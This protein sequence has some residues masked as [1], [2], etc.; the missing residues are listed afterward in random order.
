MRRISI[1]FFLSF[2]LG[3]QSLVPPTVKTQ[4]E[5]VYPPE[6]KYYVVDHV[7]AKLTMDDKGVPFAIQSDQQIPDNVVSALRKWRFE[8]ASQGHKAVGVEIS[9]DLPVRRPLS[10]AGGLGRHWQQTKEYIEGCKTARELDE[11]GAAAVDQA[12]ARNPADVQSRLVAVCYAEMHDSPENAA[13][14]LRNARWFAEINPAFEWLGGPGSTPRRELAGTED[15]E[16]LRKLWRQKL[17]A[18]PT[19]TAILDNATNFLRISDPEEA[20]GAMLKAMK[21]PDHAVDLLGDIYVLAGSGVT[22]VK[23]SGGAPE[24]RD[25]KL[26]ATPFAVL[27]R[28][29]LLKTQNM[30]LL[31][32]ALRTVSGSSDTAFCHAVLDR[33]K[34]F[35]PEAEA[36]CDGAPESQTRTVR[37]G[38]NVIAPKLIKTVRP[39][40]P[41]DAKARGIE[42]K[43]KFQAIIAQNGTIKN[44][45][46]LAGPF[47]LY[48]EARNAVLKWEYH[49]TTL[50]GKPVDVITTIDVAFGLSR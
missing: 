11:K 35:Y 39:V 20:A 4:I 42:G 44:L 1:L 28:E 33:A 36:D 6:L 30:R 38:G 16:A 43:V 41:P 13:A 2:C 23:P 3:A 29:Q 7:T 31:F 27:A 49:P 18:N 21:A 14:R 10:E 8:P 34:E 32:S 25:E 46:L 45:E 40:Y 48:D 5:P 22:A 19:D 24:A 17:A 37:I 26:A 50:N 47:A 15:Y 9:L 12:I